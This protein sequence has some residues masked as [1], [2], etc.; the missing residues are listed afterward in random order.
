MAQHRVRSSSQF[1]IATSAARAVAQTY[2]FPTAGGS[3][4]FAP[5]KGINAVRV[6]IEITAVTSTP[7]TTFAI[8]A[9]D[10]LNAQWHD[11]IVSSA[12][13]AI[14]RLYLEVGPDC[15]AVANQSAGKYIGGKIRVR[16][17]HANTNSMTY[18]IVGEWTS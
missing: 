2:T 7:S 13:A 12:Q 8:Q 18:N 10:K 4:G 11:L 3:Q 5:P 15:A 17:T 6:Y 9:Y 14:G 1:R 16:A